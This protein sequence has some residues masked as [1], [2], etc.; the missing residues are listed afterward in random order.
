M[1]VRK[2]SSQI[3]LS[4][5]HR[6]IRDYTFRLNWIFVKKSHSLNGK[7]KQ[8]QIIFLN[9]INHLNLIFLRIFCIFLTDVKVFMMHIIIEHFKIF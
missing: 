6:L 7:K 1:H 3:S 5:P 8:Y 4:S 9:K 2:V